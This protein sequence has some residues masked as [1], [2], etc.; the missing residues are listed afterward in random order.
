M[1]VVV[2]GGDRELRPVTGSAA[3]TPSGGTVCQNEMLPL[4]LKVDSGSHLTP[5]TLCLHI[6]FPPHIVIPVHREKNGIRLPPFSLL[7]S[8]GNWVTVC[9]AVRSFPVRPIS[10]SYFRKRHLGMGLK[11]VEVSWR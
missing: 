5:G 1:V 6:L 11:E 7:G 10:G 4:V 9:V 3:V 2:G 8:T